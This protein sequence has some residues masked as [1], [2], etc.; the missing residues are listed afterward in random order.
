ML[1]AV[2]AFI[3]FRWVPA[4]VELTA[5]D[6]SSD[7]YVDNPTAFVLIGVLDLG[8]V[9]P[10]ATAAAIGLRRGEPW[11]RE[12]AYAA[13]GWFALVPMAVAAMAISMEVNDDPNASVGVTILLVVAAA[14]F[15]VGAL[16][17]YAPLFRPSR[18]QPSS[19]LPLESEAPDPF[20]V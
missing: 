16:L 8:V 1:F 3:L 2:V 14:I 20:A 4:L 18:A 15:T 6:P 7:A 13:I 12:A 10:A 19:S 11:G 9:M 17:L 5:G